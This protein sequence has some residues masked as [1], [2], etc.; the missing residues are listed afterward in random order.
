[1][2]IRKFTLIICALATVL[3]GVAAPALVSA[4]AK[5]SVQCGINGAAGVNGCSTQPTTTLSDT[6]DNIVNILS[7]LVGVIA[8][9][10]VIVGGFRYITSAGDTNRLAGAKNTIIYALVGIIIVAL[11][12]TLV[13]FVIHKTTK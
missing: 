2:R 3:F 9:I 7:G 8:V 11:D 4:D 10:M 12:Q 13:H 1:M 6:I 5:S